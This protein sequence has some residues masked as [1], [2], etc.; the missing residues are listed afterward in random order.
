MRL[1]DGGEV[2]NWKFGK[3]QVFL[4]G[5]WSQVCSTNFGP[6]AVAVACRQLGYGEGTLLPQP[7]QEYYYEPLA[8]TI[9]FPQVGIIGVDCAGNEERLV[10]CSTALDTFRDFMLSR[11]CFSSD[12][13]G[14]E[15]ACVAGQLP[16]EEA[17][18]R[19]SLTCRLK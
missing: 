7:L 10:D 8:S 4:E 19:M 1:V 14:L 13:S 18:A 2:S 3:L 5:S 12:S 15:L 11:D 9:I 6:E 17:G 16:E